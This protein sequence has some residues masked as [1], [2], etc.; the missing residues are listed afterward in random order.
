MI[1]EYGQ[2]ALTFALCISLALAI[3]PLYGSFKGHQTAL[4]LGNPLSYALF[5]LTAFSFWA[6][7]YAFWSNDFTVVYVATNSNSLLP[8]YYRLTAVWGGH[9]G[10]MLLWLLTLSG[11][12]AAVAMFS[13]SLPL[14]FQGR[15]LGVMGLIAVGFYAF[16][17]FMSNPFMRSLPYFPV[18][19]RDLN[20]LLQDFGMII[21]PPMLYMGYVGFAVS[22][23]FAIAALMGGKFDSTWARW[24]RPWTLAAWMFLTL[25]AGEWC[26]LNHRAG[27]WVCSPRRG[28]GRS[29]RQ[30]SSRCLH[31]H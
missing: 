31:W 12:I 7:S 17:L 28:V 13:R 8:W 26:C 10:S 23:A 29:A 2:L 21:H 25:A 1:A 5:L 3:V 20:P 18:D 24:A 11:W 4:Q 19:G 6:L 30:S 9:E 16:V 14:Q 22:F 27:W 15:I